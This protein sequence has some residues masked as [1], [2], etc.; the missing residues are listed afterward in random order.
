MHDKAEHSWQDPL[1]NLTR[2]ETYGITKEQIVEWIKLCEHCMEKANMATCPPITPI[3]A[4]RPR[5]RYLDDL[6]DFSCYH[7]YKK[8]TIGCL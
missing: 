7:T 1:Y 5:E 4:E 6:V 3:I 2:R 8:G